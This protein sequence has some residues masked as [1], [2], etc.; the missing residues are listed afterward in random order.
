MLTEIIFGVTLTDALYT[1]VIV[2]ITITMWILIRLSANRTKARLRT[3]KRSWL[4]LK[5]VD[6]ID[7]PVSTL[8]LL[9]GAY[10]VLIGIPSLAPYEDLIRRVITVVAILLV[11]FTALRIQKHVL[12][13]YV[14]R[15]AR[16]SDH[17]KV[18]NTML[19]M[20]KRITAIVIVIMGFLVVLDELGIAIAPLV[21]GLG[22]AGLAV[23][24]ALQGTLTNFFAGINVLT[25]G[26]VRVGDYVQLDGGLAGY[27]DQIGWRTTRIRML[28]NNMIII[29]N[30]KLADSVTTNYHFPAEE[31]SLYLEVG[32]AY[33]S[34]LDHVEQVTLDV[35]NKV[36]KN[37]EGSVEG[38]PPSIWYDS[39]GD[40]NINFW[41]VIRSRGYAEMWK[42]KHNFIKA[43][44][45]RY[46]DEGIEISFPARN[47]YVKG[48][49][50]M[51][52]EFQRQRQDTS[53]PR[54]S[55]R[56]YSENANIEEAENIVFPDGDI[57]E[58]PPP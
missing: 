26:S 2:S 28:A 6:D 7:G 12:G 27:I 36:I 49:A 11:V 56:G 55:N 19:P 58:P 8:I 43:L 48:S 1:L 13:W 57:G 23:A 24:L 37:T 34:D 4:A 46:N 17:A 39:F 3:K 32:V 9:I 33:S 21:A 15:L 54:V 50:S 35:A 30:S 25:D 22:I 10:V 14:G 18:L 29:P 16:E 51:D 20:A 42:L 45:R 41:V 44:F 40:S 38:Y 47:V 52:Q 53:L 5:L 31:M